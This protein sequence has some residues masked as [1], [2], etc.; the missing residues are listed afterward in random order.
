MRCPPGSSLIKRSLPLPGPQFSALSPPIFLLSL[1]RG[2]EPFHYFLFA[3]PGALLRLDRRTLY[4]TAPPRPRPQSF[5]SFASFP[6]FFQA[7]LP[8]SARVRPLSRGPSSQ[9][10]RFSQVYIQEVRWRR[11]LALVRGFRKGCILPDRRTPAP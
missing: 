1:L 11:F 9:V 3:L 8:A 5:P 6:S 10:E 2:T 4:I 7:Q